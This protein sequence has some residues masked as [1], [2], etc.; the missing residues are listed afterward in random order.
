[1]Q[2]VARA[3][4]TLDVQYYFIGGDATGRAFLQALS[5]AD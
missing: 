3:K 4:R 2:L 5:P 1:M